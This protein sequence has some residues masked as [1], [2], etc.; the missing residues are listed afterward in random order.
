MIAIDVGARSKVSIASCLVGFRVV[1][2]ELLRLRV[3]STPT[4]NRA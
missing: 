4:T 2:G 1:V 3:H